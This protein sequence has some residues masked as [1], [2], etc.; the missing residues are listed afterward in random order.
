MGGRGSSSGAAVRQTVGSQYGEQPTAFAGSEEVNYTED[1]LEAISEYT[2][3]SVMND[4]LRYPDSYEDEE[5]LL[6][7]MDS[8]IDFMDNAMSRFKTQEDTV[9]YR[10]MT[11]EG[12]ETLFG[13]PP[14]VGGSLY[15][16]GFMSTAV[17]KV[18]ADGFR[19]GAEMYGRK[20]TNGY[21]M[22][23]KVPKG[24]GA[25]YTPT[26]KRDLGDDNAP[27]KVREVILA[28]GRSMKVSRV[29]KEG[30]ATI[31]EVEA[32]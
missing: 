6:N 4:V 26:V 31:V 32:R 23:I 22:R 10:G 19:V 2:G 14:K 9:L 17:S 30:T 18:D 1:E 8:K 28:R 20:P 16:K 29:Y 25:V 11:Q 13:G 12:F 3:S 7:D 21:V 15:D 5:D 27:K 24:T